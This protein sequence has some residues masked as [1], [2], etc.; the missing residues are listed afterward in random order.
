MN[1]REFFERQL[2]MGAA[3]VVPG[4]VGAQGMGGMGGM[5]HGMEHMPGMGGMGAGQAMSGELAVADAIAGHAPLA[6]LWRLPNGSR[7]AG[8]FQGRLEAAPVQLELIPGFKT[9][10]WAYEGHVP[11]PLIEVREGDRVEIELVNRLPQPTTIHWHGLPVPADQDG[12]P[13]D[14]VAPGERRLYRFT[15]PPGSAGTYWFHPHPHHHTAEQVFR[16]LAGVFIVRAKE[17]PLAALPERHL[18][19]SDLRLTR[20]GRIPPNGMM[21]WMN[22]REGQFVLVNGQRRP[23][24][25]I[26]E[27]QHW[28]LWN[29]CSARYLRL[30]L[31]N[32]PF[33]LVGTDGGLLASPREE[34]ELLL[35][36]GER[37]EVVVQP[38]EMPGP[39]VLVAAAY[40]R[41]KMAMGAM[42]PAPEQAIPLVDLMYRKSRARAGSV[43][44]ILRPLTPLGAVRVTRQVLL[45]EQMD[46]ARMHASMGADQPQG[47]DFLINGKTYDPMRVDF[48]SRRHEVEL[49]EL[50]NASDM[51]HPFHLHGTQF[52]VTERELDNRITPEPF[53]AWRDTVNV[54]PGE[55][56][57]IK[58][59]Q[60]LPGK[61]MFHCH[62]LEHEDLGMMGVVEVV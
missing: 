27:T 8:L 56:V 36:P 9:E 3:W 12:S 44:K 60:A 32:Q 42:G 28:R 10:A 43:P 15:L 33:M 4:L 37:A 41:G 16:G 54:R 50:M 52:Q 57:R 24:L 31:G 2:L 34:G 17:D 18:V 23:R 47:M 22:G 1:R 11:G 49:W 35:A 45:T 46:M 38:P 30:T 13:T 20:D 51:D 61:R 29:A 6:G 5:S 58:V 7:R 55:V 40:E 19:F 48:Q 53:L 62:V 39:G 26:G 25:D 14:L 21:D 59:A